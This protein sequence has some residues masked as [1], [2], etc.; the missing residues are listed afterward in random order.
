MLYS[1]MICTGGVRCGDLEGR[2]ARVHRRKG[3][4]QG[5]VGRGGT[6]G[7]V[8][9]YRGLLR[10]PGVEEVNRLCPWGTLCKK[11]Q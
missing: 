2:A 11:I 8:D 7:T 3:M 10:Y 6:V 9:C 1:I 5:T 4:R